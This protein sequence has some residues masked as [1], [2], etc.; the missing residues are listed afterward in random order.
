MPRMI[1]AAILAFAIM[2]SYGG[3]K[4]LEALL[5]PV[6]QQGGHRAEDRTHM[7]R[8]IVKTDTEWEEI[9]TPGQYRVMR[10][11]GTEPPFTGQYNDHYAE[12]TYVCA[13]CRAP[14]FRWDSKYDHGS[15]WPSFTSPVGDEAVETREDLSFG[16]RRIEVLCASCGAHLGHLFDDGPAPTG[17][18][19]CVNSTALDF[20]PEGARAG[21]TPDGTPAAVPAIPV[22]DEKAPARTLGTATFAAGCFWAVEYKFRQLKGVTDAI[23]GYTGGATKDPTYAQVCSERTG[24]AEAVRVTFDPDAVSYEELVR[25]F[26]TIHDPTQVDRQGSDVGTQYRSIIFTHDETQAAT[27]RKVMAEVGASGRFN[28]PLATAIVP[29]PEFTRAEDW[30]Q[31]YYEKSGMTSC[32]F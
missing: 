2:V 15:G 21:D 27:A 1:K 18:H 5:G 16:M 29:A 30:H 13:A 25:F 12:G 14:L 4:G 10:Q 24:H 26:F 19:F 28:E 3:W 11:C 22:P 20:L 31:R 17:E 32:A 23:S 9:L 7:D 6:R 8:K